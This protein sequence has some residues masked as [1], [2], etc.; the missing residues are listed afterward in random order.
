[1]ASG[2]ASVN[3]GS[4]SRSGS[5][6]E[7]SD[8][9]ASVTDIDRASD[10]V[11]DHQ[12]CFGWRIR[13]TVTTDFSGLN[14]SQ[15]KT[16]PKNQI[17][18]PATFLNKE[19]AVNREGIPKCFSAFS[20]QCSRPSLIKN[21]PNCK[22]TLLS[23]CLKARLLKSQ[24]CFAERGSLLYSRKQ[25]TQSTPEEFYRNKHNRRLSQVLRSAINP[26]L[27]NNSDQFEVDIRKIRIHSTY[28]APT[29]V[30]VRRVLKKFLA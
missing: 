20:S 6:K 14:L 5:E 4:P 11:F 27:S 12:I 2:R 21:P 24:S 26:R 13:R 15:S 18:I 10:D 16:L 23:R 25:N 28:I 3:S 7:N 8:T 30:H 22:E 17:T 29:D 9:A 1:M 19:T